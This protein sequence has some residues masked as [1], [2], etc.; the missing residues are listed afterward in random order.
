MS[1][2]GIFNVDVGGFG[3][4]HQP[5]IVFRHFPQMLENLV[6]GSSVVVDHV[7]VHGFPR[8]LDAHEHL[9]DGRE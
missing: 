1:L 6:H 4:P 9:E 5:L 3:Q 2:T 8:H 7:L